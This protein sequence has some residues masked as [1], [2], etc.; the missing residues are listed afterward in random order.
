MQ[1]GLLHIAGTVEMNNEISMKTNFTQL[2]FIMKCRLGHVLILFLF[3]IS[4]LSYSQSSESFFP[5]HVGDRRDYYVLNT[6]QVFSSIITK[7]SIG[8]DGSHN[9]FYNNANVPGYRID[10]LLNV[11]VLPQDPFVNY[12]W[13]KLGADKCQSWFNPLAGSTRWAWVA[14]IESSFVFTQSSVLKTFFYAPGNPCGFGA[15]VINQLAEGFGLVYTWQEPDDTNY[16]I[17]CII[18]GDTFGYISSYANHF[19]NIPR[20]IQLYQNY[21]NP[22]NTM[23]NIEFNTSMY[24]FVSLKVYNILGQEVSTLIENM[25]LPG[26]HHAKW[27]GKEYP[28]GMY[29]YRLSA[30]KFIAT[31]KMVLMK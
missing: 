19:D 6:G 27:D 10:T 30:G 2:V 1:K 31:K 21:P 24:G 3:F 18:A 29:F 17:G 23:T 8:E 14:Q 22:F 5:H 20:G 25:V 16:L 15:L 26:E 13:F 4:S 7:D 11:Y 9:I 28:S 12:L